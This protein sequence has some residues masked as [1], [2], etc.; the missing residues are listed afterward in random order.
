MFES[1][2]ARRAQAHRG[3]Q[4]R[5]AQF[6][7]II[8]MPAHALTAVGIIIEQ[9]AVKARAHTRFDRRLDCQH[10]VLPGQRDAGDAGIG[11]RDAMIAQPR[12]L[13]RRHNALAI[14]HDHIALPGNFR[15]QTRQ[16]GIGLRRRKADAVIVN[17][18]VVRQEIYRRIGKKHAQLP[19][20][21]LP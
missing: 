9:T 6:F 15:L 20:T 4:R 16:I 14:E 17:D 11:I 13:P 5:L 12:R 19:S 10:A 3:N 7:F 18:A 1:K 8:A 2:F 21:R